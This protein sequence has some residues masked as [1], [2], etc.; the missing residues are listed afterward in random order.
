M[1][2]KYFIEGYKLMNEYMTE[3]KIKTR[4]RNFRRR[5]DTFY[6]KHKDKKVLDLEEEKEYL[7]LEKYFYNNIL[8]PQSNEEKALINA[9]NIFADVEYDNKK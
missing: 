5:L 7:Q 9:L 1:E 3:N 2:G 6:K 4:E 8:N